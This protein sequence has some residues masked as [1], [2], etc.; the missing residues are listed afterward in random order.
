[1]EVRAAF[2]LGFPTE[3]P[4]MADRTIRFACEINPDFANFVPYHVWPGTPMEEF[5]LANGR[6]IPWN[7]DLLQPSYVPDSFGSFEALDHKVKEA[8]RRFY[9]RPQYFASTLWRLREPHFA[10]RVLSGLRY[11]LTLMRRNAAKGK[12]NSA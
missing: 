6:C 8:Y 1:M 7:D 10:R 9:L 3:T 4:E 5:S 2:I 12:D 11:W